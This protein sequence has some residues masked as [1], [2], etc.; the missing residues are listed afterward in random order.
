MNDA[1][2]LEAKKIWLDRFQGASLH[3]QAEFG[4]PLVQS[5]FRRS[6]YITAR[7][8][9]FISVFGRALLGEDRVAQPEIHVR[10]AFRNAIED[11]DRKIRAAEALLKDAAIVELAAYALPRRADVQIITPV[12]RRHLE[13]LEKAD[14]FL[15][16]VNTLWLHGRID[17][18][19]RARSELE[20]KRKLR[21]VV[22]AARNMFI[23]LRNEMNVKKTEE[24][25][26]VTATAAVPNA[27]AANDPGEAADAAA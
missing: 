2:S 22:S 23:A 6:F 27:G 19:Q 13:L 9:H 10:N 8:A 24:S 21:G 14:A 26:G 1:A 20:V 4:N 11:V 25:G 12:S 16:L 17:G 7:N 15:L 3:V 18:T 5:A